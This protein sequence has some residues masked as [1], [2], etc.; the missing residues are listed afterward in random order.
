MFA[1]AARADQAIEMADCWTDNMVLQQGVSIPLAGTSEPNTQITVTFSG[2][3]K[4]VVS[5]ERG[6]WAA[7]LD[8]LQPSPRPGTLLVS[9]GCDTCAKKFIN[10]VVGDVWIS[11]GTPIG[12][13]DGEPA[14]PFVN[15]LIR[16]RHLPRPADGR[17]DSS[18][19]RLAVQW[20][21]CGN[22][23][24]GG[25]NP[26]DFFF[27]QQLWIK[28]SAPIGVI[29]YT[30]SRSE[31]P[32]VDILAVSPFPVRGILWS[33]PRGTLGNKADAAALG[34]RITTWRR[35]AVSDQA[36]T[37]LVLFQADSGD[38]ANAMK[39]EL[40]DAWPD[41]PRTHV[42]V[43]HPMNTKLLAVELAQSAIRSD[44]GGR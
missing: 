19:D 44:T 16:M 40:R 18:A 26:L 21:P 29:E 23:V 9:T 8:P 3:T 5:D 2:Q 27:A 36:N 13:S 34:G 6:C 11:G 4:T 32:P 25:I 24:S 12:E 42:R 41:Q 10:L 39:T 37:N 20:L 28:K 35:V 14:A 38:V 1:A 33:M 43:F 17:D 15:T 22:Q 31:L 7:N 30:G